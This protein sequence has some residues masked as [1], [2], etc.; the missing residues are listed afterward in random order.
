MAKCFCGCGNKAKGVGPR[1]ANKMGEKTL[2]FNQGLRYALG[3]LRE[4]EDQFDGDVGPALERLEELL[5]RGADYE[6]FWAFF[7]HGGVVADTA[8]LVDGRREWYE[9]TKDAKTLS[10]IWTMTPEQMRAYRDA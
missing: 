8:E 7:V 6:D 9:W 10:A 1:G 3:V 4:R 2:E 5:R